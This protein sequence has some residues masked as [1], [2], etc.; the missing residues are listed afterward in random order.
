MGIQSRVR[1]STCSL[2][3]LDGGRQGNS[4]QFRGNSPC[5]SWA[6]D[7]QFASNQGEWHVDDGPSSCRR[8]PST[9]W[10]ER[11]GRRPACRLRSAQDVSGGPSAGVNSRTINR[12]LPHLTQSR[13]AGTR[14]RWFH[15][16]FR[17][18]GFRRVHRLLQRQH[19]QPSRRAGIRPLHPVRPPPPEEGARPPGGKRN[20]KTAKDCMS[21][22]RLHRRPSSAAAATLTTTVHPGFEAAVCWSNLFGARLSLVT[23]RADRQPHLVRRNA[24]APVSTPCFSTSDVLTPQIHSAAIRTGE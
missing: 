5:P 9:R 12:W 13:R 2:A 1:F 10:H 21:P 7:C 14:A 15:D 17:R 23:C 8:T 6:N 3:A 4:S 11:R 16:N 19:R 20:K 24:H 22:P 18:M